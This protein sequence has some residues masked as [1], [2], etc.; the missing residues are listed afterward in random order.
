MK[1]MH[2][3]VL[4]L[5]MGLV[6]G[7]LAFGGVY[8][9][10]TRSTRAMLEEPRADLAWLRTEFH[11]DPIRYGKVARLHEAYE[12][13]CARI[14]REVADANARLSE[15]ALSHRELNDDLRRLIAET[16][17]LRDECRRAML[18]H[19][20]AVARELPPD[21]AQRYLRLM[22]DSTCVVEQPRMPGSAHS[23]DAHA[24]E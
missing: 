6:A 1:R 15:T 20:Y 18:E 2:R 4:I 12:T 11:L 3:P 24:N 10:Q 8:A 7:L 13:N 9:W 5:A 22:L 16:G 21:A 19:L 14:C 23:M 17:R